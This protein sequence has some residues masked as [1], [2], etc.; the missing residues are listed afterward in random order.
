MQQHPRESIVGTAEAELR[1]AFSS[2]VEK[3]NLTHGEIV[4]VLASLML[5][6]AQYQLR[7]ERQPSCPDTQGAGG[8]AID[9][10]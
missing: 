4:A 1:M 7:D 10:K 5:R 9:D 3:H 2:I 6:R 8:L